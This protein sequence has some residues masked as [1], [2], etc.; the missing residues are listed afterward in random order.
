MRLRTLDAVLLATA[1]SLA[2]ASLAQTAAASTGAAAAPSGASVANAGAEGGGPAIDEIIVTAQRVRESL[3]NVPLSVTAFSGAALKTANITN[4]ER[5]EQVTPGLLV[6]RSGSDARFAIRGINTEAIGA[7]SDPRIGFYVDDVY[8]SRTSQALAS[9]VD[10]ERVE[11]QKGPQGTLYGRNSFGG[12][13]ALYSAAPKDELGAGADVLYGRYNRL[14]TEGFVNVPV[15]PGIAARVAGMYERADGYVK[16]TSTGSNLGDED[17]YFVRG[18]LRIAPQGSRFEAVVRG[19]YWHEGGN[20]ISAFG[21]K[22]IG[23]PVDRSRIVQPGGTLTVGGIPITFP[24]GFNSQSLY[25]PGLPINSRFRDGIAD[26]GGVDIGIPIETDPYRINFDTVTQRKTTQVQ[27][28]ARLSYDAG[29][30][31]LRSITGYADFYSLRTSD[32]DFSP[33]PVAIDYNR[34]SVKTYSQEVQIL[35][36]EHN[37]SRLKWIVGG[38]FYDDDVKEFFFS[39]N[40]PQYPL[41]GQQA[42]SSFSI[43][44]FPGL[45]FPNNT[46]L[47]NNRSDNFSPVNLHTRSYAGFGQ[48]TFKFSDV[49]SATGGVR[50]TSDRKHYAAGFSPS[51]PAGTFLAFDQATQ[52]PGFNFTCGSSTAALPSSTAPAATVANGVAVRCGDKT[53]NFFTYRAALNAQVTRDNL[54]YASVSSGRRSGGFNNS[55]NLDNSAIAFNPE[56]VTA[57][58]IGSKNRFRDGT[59]Q[60]NASAFYNK[61]SGLQVQRQVPAPNGLTTI[62]IIENAGQARSYGA[63][64]EMVVKPTPHLTF[65]AAFTYLNSRYTQY[66]TGTASNGICA[67]INCAA[68][69][70]TYPG[71]SAIGLG[72]SGFA[73][74]NALSDPGRFKRIFLANGTPAVAGGLPVYNYIIAGQGSDGKTYGATIPFSPEYTV[75]TG[76]AYDIDLPG[77][78]K[79][80]PSVQTFLNSGFFNTDFNTPL[81]RQHAYTKTDLRL[82][83]ISAGGK[84]SAQVYLENAEN[85]AVL[86]RVAIGANRSYNGVYEVP[87]TYGVKAGFRF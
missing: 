57:Y 17:Q 12:N 60:L 75:R 73:F 33:A 18:S 34:T 52:A 65:N 19:S 48:A 77:G 26:V 45:P 23:T 59:V 46:R 78:G 84:Y 76:L 11:V 20:G 5:L 24:N 70:A 74:P 13:V 8:Q 30:V 35:S 72:P 15:T 66:E 3:Q 71:I 62:S 38:Y 14:R 6:G 41:P 37:T 64:V 2:Q 69:E 80:T 53:F 68:L 32:N 42:L 85:T 39:D 49:F 87:R 44:A 81:D 63:E 36:S 83:F 1:C 51:A 55:P 27:F 79:L 9:F 82:S 40:F 25:A 43:T 50:Y 56:K 86:N 22:S 47:T 10:L 31:T 7:N 54:L 4:V 58:E 67:Q 29:P 28:S 21:Y 16:N 61:Y